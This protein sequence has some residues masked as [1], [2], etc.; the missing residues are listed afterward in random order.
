MKFTQ[1]QIVMFTLKEA[2]D[3][4][5]SHQLQKIQTK[6]GWLGT[7]GDRVARK[8]AEEGKIERKMINGYANF[9]II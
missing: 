5:P 4:T 6:Y 9:K 2:K 1:K 7:S 8:L 3:W